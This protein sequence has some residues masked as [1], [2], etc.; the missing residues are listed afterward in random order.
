MRLYLTAAAGLALLTAACDGRNDTEVSVT[1]S[2]DEARLQPV[3][4]LDCPEREGDLRLASRD[5][6]GR[7]CFYRA[8][9]AEV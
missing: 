1:R 2:S 6:A 8:D 9:G 4:A 7:S 5:P 3:S